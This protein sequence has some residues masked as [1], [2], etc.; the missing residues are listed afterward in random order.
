MNEAANKQFIEDL[1]IE[2]GTE[3]AFLEKD[4]YAVQLLKHILNLQLKHK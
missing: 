4:W 2:L 3:S 1:A